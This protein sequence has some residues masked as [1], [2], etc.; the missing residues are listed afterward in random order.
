MEQA[1][2]MVKTLYR[3]PLPKDKPSAQAPMLEGEILALRKRYASVMY[4]CMCVYVLCVRVRVRVRAHVWTYAYTTWTYVSGQASVCHT[5]THTHMHTPTHPHTQAVGRASKVGSM[6]EQGTNS[7]KS[8]Y[9][10]TVLFSRMKTPG[11]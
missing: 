4:A 7:A 2:T 8:A 10:H 11:R 9:M 5:H 3:Q 6:G 1:L